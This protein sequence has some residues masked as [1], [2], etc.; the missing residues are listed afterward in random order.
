MCTGR[1]CLALARGRT[2]ELEAD[3]EEFDRHAERLALLAVFQ[4]LPVVAR[5]ASG[6]EVSATASWGRLRRLAATELPSNF[7]TLGTIALAAMSCVGTGSEDT[8]RSLYERYR[9]YAGLHATIGAYTTL[10]SLARYIGALADLCGE[11]EDAIAYYERAIEDN[12]K[13]QAAPW[14]VWSQ[15]ELAA[16]LER[17]GATGDGARA[18]ALRQEA[19]ASRAALQMGDHGGALGSSPSAAAAPTSGQIRLA[20]DGEFWTLAVGDQTHHLKGQIGLK[21]LASLLERPR[22]DVHVLDLVGSQRLVQSDLGPQLDDTARKAYLDRIRKLQA[23]IENAREQGDYGAGSAAEDE[24]DALTRQLAG[25]QGLGGRARAKGAS[26]E[27]ARVA[28]TRALRRAIA[29]IRDVAPDLGARLD[30]EVRTGTHCRYQ[31]TEPDLRWS[32]HDEA[33]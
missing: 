6:G 14:L 20:R 13:M 12:A 8:A 24:L 9:H 26:T 22:E 33:D 27:R 1:V 23:V 7:L 17:R 11:S 31:P 32:V 2:D 16:L 18:A 19:E 5:L 29:S 4:A 15:L 30:Q 3:I 28:V 10:G 21:H 25:A